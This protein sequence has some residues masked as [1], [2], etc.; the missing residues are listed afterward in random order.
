[1]L[2]NHINLEMLIRLQAHSHGTIAT[3][4]CLSQL[5]GYMEFSVIGAISL[6]LH[7]IQHICCEKIA[8]TIIPFEQP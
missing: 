5:I 1:M 4:V 3:A 8:V 6:T 7:P 2:L